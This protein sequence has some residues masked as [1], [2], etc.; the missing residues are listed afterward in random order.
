MKNENNFLLL[1]ATG[2]AGAIFAI[3]GNVVLPESLRADKLMAV[4]YSVAMILFAVRDYSRRPKSINLRFNPLLRPTPR[5]FVD[6]RKPVATP[7]KRPAHIEH[8][9]A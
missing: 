5:I 1:L 7:G 3:L 9:A 2:L 4:F 6:A 8:H